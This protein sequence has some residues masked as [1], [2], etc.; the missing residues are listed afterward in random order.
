M[1]KGYLIGKLAAFVLIGDL[2]F[3]FWG[4][5]KEVKLKS[6]R[7]VPLLFLN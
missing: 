3:I 5:Y 6:W 2:L 7:V 1:N 4:V